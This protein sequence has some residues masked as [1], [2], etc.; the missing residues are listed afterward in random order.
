MGR[1]LREITALHPDI[2]ALAIELSHGEA[3][4][5]A[6]ASA[7]VALVA[8]VRAACAL[9]SLPPEIGPSL[10]RAFEQTFADPV[11]GESSTALQLCVQR[12]TDAG[13]SD[14]HGAVLAVHGLDLLTENEWATNAIEDLEAGRLPRHRVYAPI[15]RSRRIAFRNGLRTFLAILISAILLSFGGW[16][17]A[18]EAVAMVGIMAAISTTTPNP[19][20]F[21]TDALIAIPFAALL[22]GATEFLILDGVDQFPLLTIGMA[23]SVIV[24]VLLMTKPKPRLAS[25]AYLVLVFV[26]VMLSPTNRRTIALKRTCS[27]VSWWSCPWCCFPSSF[28]PS[29]RFPTRLCGTGS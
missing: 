24:P 6:A 29:C 21:A 27:S 23:P 15:Y 18:A 2:T 17:F 10:R 1:I 4:A 28:G 19:S 13:Y 14:P 22:A 20:S 7:S 8:E 5:E 12:H 25:I 9:A 16:P 3:E 26:P 11:G